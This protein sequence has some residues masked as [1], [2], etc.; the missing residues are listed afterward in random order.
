MQL[1]NQ[2][3]ISSISAF[4]ARSCW[5][6]HFLQVSWPSSFFLVHKRGH[7]CFFTSLLGKDGFFMQSGGRPCSRRCSSRN[8]QWL[9]QMGLST[10]SM[11]SDDVGP[12][13]VLDFSH[14][15]SPSTC[16]DWLKLRDSVFSRAGRAVPVWIQL[17]KSCWRCMWINA[18][19]WQTCL[20]ACQGKCCRN[21]WAAFLINS[22][23]KLLTGNESHKMSHLQM[24][25]AHIGFLNEPLIKAWF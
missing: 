25:D 6:C 24:N 2:A 12:L 16:S 7:F 4:L 11:T 17:K 14:L 1:W 3:S 10:V 13:D 21:P 22:F 15:A 20:N 18:D 8:P 5:S 19:G 23:L 9:Q